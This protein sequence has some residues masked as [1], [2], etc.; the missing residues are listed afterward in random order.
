MKKNL[1]DTLFF[2]FVF[3][4]Y[5]T[6]SI[7]IPVYKPECLFLKPE[8]KDII[9]EP[10]MSARDVANLI[11][12]EGIVSDSQLLTKWMVFYK[13]DKTL[14]PGK[15]TLLKA[16]EMDL[17]YNLQKARPEVSMFMI[18]PGEK[19]LNLVNKFKKDN[20]DYFTKEIL[21]D[22][23]FPKKIIELLPNLP[24]D[25]I[26]FLLPES[27]PLP[28]GNGA[29]KQFV[30]ESSKLWFEK[31]GLSISLEDLT[32][33]T[34]NNSAI[35]ASIIEGEAKL[36]EERAILAGVFL[37]RIRKNMKLQSCATVIYSWNLKGIRKN[38]LSYKDLE[39]E[40]SYNTYRK[41]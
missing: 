12:K 20:T 9:I 36:N 24:E 33:E 40:S 15:Y 13:I 6:Y 4:L 10:G 41:S 11:E 22:N 29:A 38:H 39:I 5:I 30:I 34:L 19:Y 37:N 27:Y 28:P 35:L 3:V 25:R 26:A 14:R 8:K 31:I 32:K 1:L 23:N 17:A 7:I 2:I 16:H 18:V 21:N